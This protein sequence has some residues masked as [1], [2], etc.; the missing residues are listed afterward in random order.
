[1]ETKSIRIQLNFLIM[2]FENFENVVFG[3]KDQFIDNIPIKDGSVPYV[4]GIV[5]KNVSFPISKQDVQKCRKK[6]CFK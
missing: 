4:A 6:N 3:Y 5:D 1:M 2:V